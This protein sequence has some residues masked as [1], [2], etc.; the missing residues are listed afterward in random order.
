MR[1]LDHV[2]QKFARTHAMLC[3]TDQSPGRCYCN[4]DQEQAAATH[5]AVTSY[6]DSSS[7]CE[8]EK[9]VYFVSVAKRSQLSMFLSIYSNEEVHEG[10]TQ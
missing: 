9:K 2:A 7:H 3:E 1:A 10:G 5:Q 8:L 6:H 4:D